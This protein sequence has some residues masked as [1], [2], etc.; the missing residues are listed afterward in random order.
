LRSPSSRC[1]DRQR[2]RT[3]RPALLAC[4]GSPRDVDVDTGHDRGIVRAAAHAGSCRAS[5]TD[6]TGSPF[7]SVGGFAARCQNRAADDGSRARGSCSPTGRAA[8][9]WRVERATRCL[10]SPPARWAGR[11]SASR[12]AYVL[13]ARVLTRCRVRPAH[14]MRTTNL[15]QIARARMQHTPTTS[16]GQQSSVAR[17]AR[18]A[19]AAATR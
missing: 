17:A 6:G 2:D 16:T 9:G 3:R 5:S 10:A 13:S 8:F 7:A 4:A 15:P 19:Q 1:C 14:D 11:R 12:L 18:L